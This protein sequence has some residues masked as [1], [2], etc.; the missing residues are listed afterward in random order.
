MASFETVVD[1]YDEGR[2]HY[3]AG[4][5]DALGSLR[6]LVVLDVGAGTGIATRQL[7]ERGA[8]VV[9]VDPGIQLLTRAI[10]RTPAL[11]A[12]AADGAAM[13]FAEATFDLACFAQSWHW[14]NPATRCAEVHRVL[15]TNGRWAAWWS[16]ARADASAWFDTYWSHV[17]AA[18]PG[19]NR[20]QRDTDWGESIAVSGLFDVSPLTVVP[21]V[22]TLT[23]DAWLTDQSSHSYVAHLPDEERAQLMNQLRSTLLDAFP[24]GHMSVPYE[25]YLWVAQRFGEHRPMSNA[26]GGG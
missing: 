14:L 25:T 8:N 6:G 21:W 5:F 13:P 23:V 7:L 4:V 1:E 24:D 19:T 9:A 26:A 10:H 12:I 2:P 20:R 18:C 15:R 22:R 17:E 16:H 3:P 11:D